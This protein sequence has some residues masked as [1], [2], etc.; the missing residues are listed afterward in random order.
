MAQGGGRG[1]NPART[2]VG[3]ACGVGGASLGPTTPQPPQA[4]GN[5][6]HWEF[7]AGPAC[8]CVGEM[9]HD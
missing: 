6:L 4:P 7:G 2:E 3:A 5:C 8:C 9:Q 1:E